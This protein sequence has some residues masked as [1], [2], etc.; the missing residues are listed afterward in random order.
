[1]NLLNRFLSCSLSGPLKLWLTVD[2][3]GQSISIR[4]AGIGAAL[5][6]PQSHWCRGEMGGP[7]I[8]GNG[9]SA[10]LNKTRKN[11]SGVSDERLEARL[12]VGESRGPC[13]QRHG[14][15]FPLTG[16]KIKLFKAPVLLTVG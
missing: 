5:G 2:R 9:G 4:E 6:L 3:F 7:W 16:G 10:P 14:W 12:V 13:Y 8:R 1:M 11:Q 15:R